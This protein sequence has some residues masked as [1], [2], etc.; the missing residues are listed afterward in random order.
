[1]QEIRT[2]NNW[3][4]DRV[5][6]TATWLIWTDTAGIDMETVPGT[7]SHAHFDVR[8]ER[9]FQNQTCSSQSHSE[10]ASCNTAGLNCV[11]YCKIA[12]TYYID[13]PISEPEIRSH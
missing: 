12:A 10:F 9:V 5:L 1:M 4:R 11:S 2:P 8:C 7:K 13:V 6:R 3:L